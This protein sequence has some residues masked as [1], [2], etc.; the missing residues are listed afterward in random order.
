[1]GSPI[2]EELSGR[3]GKK[4]LMVAVFGDCPKN[5]DNYTD[6]FVGMDIFLPVC[7]PSD[8]AVVISAQPSW[9]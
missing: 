2:F 1:M 9:F 7:P 6:W 5:W 3:Y 8:T 4:G